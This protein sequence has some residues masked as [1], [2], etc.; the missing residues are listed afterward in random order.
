MKHSVI[1]IVALAVLIP[2]LAHAQCE[3]DTDCRGGRVCRSGECVDA[4]ALSCGK[5]T[6]CPDPM[7]C[8]EARCTAPAPAPSAPSS[9]KKDIVYAER[10]SSGIPEIW[11]PGLITFTLAWG[12]TIGITAGTGGQGDQIAFAAIPAFGPFILLGHERTG[13]DY[14][15]PLILSGVFQTAGLGF[16]I[17][18]LA[19]TKTER[20]PVGVALQDGPLPTRLVVLP[21]PV[22]TLDSF[23]LN[24]SLLNL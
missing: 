17:A 16:F 20:V 1:I 18:G 7:L 11:V 5:D 15:A 10:Q 8:L 24:L 6:D 9:G 4:A 19:M 3:A 23:G 14:I 2:G 12:A 21:G 22:G 13:D